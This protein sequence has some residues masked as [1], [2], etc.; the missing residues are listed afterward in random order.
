MDA[1]QRS[2]GDSISDI[3]GPVLNS[4]VNGLTVSVFLA[5]VF[6][7]ALE[8]VDQRTT[9]F[10]ES[11]K[12]LGTVASKAFAGDFE[13]AAKAIR[14]GEAALREMREEMGLASIR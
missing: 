2:V 1:I 11:L 6:N 12:Q 10:M 4:L 9:L 5:D 7:G 8:R 13:G 14:D 3:A